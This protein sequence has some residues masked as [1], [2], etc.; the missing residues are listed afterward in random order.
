VSLVILLILVVLWLVV[1]A[2]SIWKRYTERRTGESINSFHQGLHLLERTGPKLVAPAFRLETA[3][4]E[5]GLAPGQSGF[6]A[7]SS[8]PGRPKLVLLRPTDAGAEMVA[9]RQ[10][11]Y[12][13]ARAAS[14][15]RARTEQAA[16]RRAARRRRRDILA[17]L[18]VT[19]VFSA[20]LGFV[21]SLRLLWV[22]AA[23]CAVALG[24]F[25]LLAAY[26]Q[27][28]GHGHQ[29][30]LAQQRNPWNS[31]ARPPEVGNWW[32]VDPRSADGFYD[33]FEYAEPIAAAR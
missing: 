2:P 7:I 22:V 8:I 20:S 23:L 11:L 21:H 13:D 16:R 18:A 1:L 5:T 19:L 12:A 4:A 31:T 3:H 24:G 33:D 25:I 9:A 26:A 6:P 27:S 17:V 29:P 10:P 14:A 32:E 15:A 30:S 28:L